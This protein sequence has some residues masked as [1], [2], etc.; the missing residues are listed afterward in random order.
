[1]ECRGLRILAQEEPIGDSGADAAEEE[2]GG[3]GITQ[4][5]LPGGNVQELAG[6]CGLTHGF[7]V[8][9]ILA[10]HRS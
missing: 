4:P 6:R 1:M 2:A 9:P 8:L 3:T 10:R 5:V 7:K